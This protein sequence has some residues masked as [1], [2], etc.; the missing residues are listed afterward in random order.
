[1]LSFIELS[2]YNRVLG[3]DLSHRHVPAVTRLLQG[4]RVNVLFNRIDCIV[5]VFKTVGGCV[6][7]FGPQ[8]AP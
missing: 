8:S 1:M 7:A 2:G 5:I 6:L 3:G 4:V